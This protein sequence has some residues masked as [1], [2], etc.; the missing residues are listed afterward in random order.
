MRIKIIFIILII[1]AISAIPVL[2]AD[3]REIFSGSTIPY[4]MFIL[5]NSGSMDSTDFFICYSSD[6]AKKA[7]FESYTTSTGK[8]YTFSTSYSYYKYYAKRITV[9]KRV[10][11]ELVDVFRDDVKMGLSH[12]FFEGS[13]SSKAHGALVFAD[14]GDYSSGDTT[15]DAGLNAITDYIYTKVNADEYTP[16]AES[17]DTIY[18]YFAGKISSTD[19]NMWTNY[20]ST[21]RIPTGSV[22]PAQYT[23]QSTFTILITDGEP[24][25]DDFTKYYSSPSGYQYRYTG[26]TSKLLDETA[27]WI[28]EH[29]IAPA[30]SGIATYTVGMRMSGTGADLLKRTA[31]M[32]HGRGR[33]FPGNDYSELKESLLT[34]IH[35]ILQRN[36]AFSAYTS[37]KR[38]T[39]ATDKTN[40]SF[41]GYFLNKPEGTPI[42][43]GHLECLEIVEDGDTYMFTKK[44][45]AAAQMPLAASRRLWTTISGTGTHL[46]TQDLDFSS[47]ELSTLQPLL[48]AS[49]ATEAGEIIS[50]I[51][52]ESTERPTDGDGNIYLLGDIFHSEVGYSGIPLAWK[53]F[54]NPP[55]CNTA[56]PTADDD[57]YEKFYNDHI[58]RKSV[59]FAGTNDGI[60][61]CFNAT[62]EGTDQGTE[63]WGFVPDEVLPRLREIA[64]DR[65]YT[66]TVDGY[67]SID[68]IYTG[69]GWKTI[70]VFGQREGGKAYYCFDITDPDPTADHPDLLWKFPAYKASGS[71]K[72][73]TGTVYTL[74]NNSG[75]FEVGQY[76]VNEQRTAK[77]KVT[78]V[79]IPNITVTTLEGTF[80]GESSSGAGDGD[81]ILALPSYYK[82]IGDSWSKPLIGRIRYQK[83]STGTL[84]TE[85]V[86]II[87]GGFN[88]DSEDEGKSIFILNATTGEP[89]WMF[90]YD[91]T[92]SG[93]DSNDNIVTNNSVITK[94]IYHDYQIP[95]GLTAVDLSNNYYLDTIFY[96]NLG[97]NLFKVDMSNPLTTTWAPKTIFRTNDE[98]QPIYIQ[99]SVSYDVCYNLWVHF[100]TGNRDKPQGEPGSEAGK[101]VAIKIDSRIPT[102]GCVLTNLQNISSYWD[103]SDDTARELGSGSDN[104]EPIVLSSDKN[105]WYFNFPAPDEILMEP[106]PLVLPY[107]STPHLY[108]NT[109]QP[110]EA[111]VGGDPCGSGGNMRQYD[112][113]LQTCGLQI[114][115]ERQEA[116]IQGGGMLGGT[117][118]ILYI[119]EPST[120]SLQQKEFKQFDLPYPGGVLFWK[121]NKR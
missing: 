60:F 9:L 118:Y 108:F 107:N 112:I 61:H 52:G 58:A 51:R 7:E 48:Q 111:I 30:T 114:L 96:G 115:G 37:P 95:V 119:G 109:Y 72:T 87:T 83:G 82:Y 68:D 8:T 41:S 74:E 23:C 36:F 13:G 69:T 62:L 105:G 5:D 103:N 59:I 106:A 54:Y 104:E 28:F 121:E 4:I 63:L 16:L 43:E 26:T 33:Y 27:K 53:K 21:N 117:Q 18:G 57:C 39:T 101:L 46:L 47:S 94:S 31:D 2:K 40:V 12:Y 56:D 73:I 45:D 10:A 35:D 110:S 92:L 22:T 86:V 67:T 89:I 38:L 120:G 49:D 34:A 84:T 64:V 14:V 100:G 6:T 70:L 55:A 32:D 85:W 116:R 80:T 76:V 17:L 79:S 1:L 81:K 25:A 15:R 19:G 29:P 88:R 24:T 65:R 20:K 50:Y 78:A 98:K 44:W 75:T 71:I 113:D 3:D 99:P 97:G 102:G 11:I 91:D 93:Y 77:G 42:W 66:Y 90:A